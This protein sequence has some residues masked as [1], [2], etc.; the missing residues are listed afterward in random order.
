[1]GERPTALT[2]KGREHYNHPL[3]ISAQNDAAKAVFD[4]ADGEIVYYDLRTDAAEEKPLTGPPVEMRPPLGRQL[5]DWYK[6]LAKYEQDKGE[7]TPEDLQQLRSL[8]YLDG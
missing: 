6:G 7:L 4:F 5:S 3:V 2:K 8:G 1:M